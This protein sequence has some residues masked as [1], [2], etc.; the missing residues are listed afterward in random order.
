[1]SLISVAE[2]AA[3]LDDPDLRIADVRWSLAVP[4]AGRVAYAAAHLP[5]AVFVDLD[6]VLTAPVGAG[7][8]PLPDPATFAAALG[9]LGIGRGHRIVAYDDAGGTVAARL[10]WML[11]ALG[12]AG[13]AVLDG[14]IDAWQAAGQPVT[15]AVPAFAAAEPVPTPGAGSAWP[16]TIDRVT[17]AARLGGV[18]I[19]DARAR[20]RYRGDVEPIDRIAGHIPTARSLPTTALLA[21]GGRFLAADALVARFAAAGV[22]AAAPARGDAALVARAAGPVVVSCGSGVNA[23][24]LALGMRA[25]GL[26]DPLLYPGSYSD[27]TQAGMPIATGDEPGAPPRSS[28]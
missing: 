25:A 12:Q 27:W 11:D 13:A 26:P 4:A 24:Q 1:V 16:R 23:C 20:E 14:G 9:A 18:T 7:R 8:H 15:A 19:L 17:L 21:P 28:G 5:G 6:T 10:W 3:A 22:D 2:L